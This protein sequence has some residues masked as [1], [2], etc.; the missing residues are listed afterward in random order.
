MNDRTAEFQAA[1]RAQTGLISEAQDLLTRY[2]AKQIEAPSLIA[3]L[4]KL[5]DGPE[6]READRLSREALGEKEPGNIA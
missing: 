5:L 4:L 6:Q 3:G 1:I 2:L